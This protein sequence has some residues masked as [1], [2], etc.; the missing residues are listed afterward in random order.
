MKR[1]LLLFFVGLAT[2]AAAQDSDPVPRTQAAEH[3]RAP[4]SFSAGVPRVPLSPRQ[5]EEN[6]QQQAL[7]QAFGQKLLIDFNAALTCGAQVITLQTQLDAV[8]KE[9]AALKSQ[10]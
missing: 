5:Q 2:S 10:N 8:K 1:L 3:E 4:P 9:L 7:Q 6:S